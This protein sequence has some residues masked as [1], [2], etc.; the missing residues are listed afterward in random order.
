MKKLGIILLSA[1]LLVSSVSAEPA[2]GPEPLAI[3]W[4]AVA[5]AKVN[6]VVGTYTRNADFKTELLKGFKFGDTRAWVTVNWKDMLGF[7]LRVNFPDDLNS[8]GPINASLFNESYLWM[9]FKYFHTDIGLIENREASLLDDVIDKVKYGYFDPEKTLKTYDIGGMNTETDF[10][11][12]WILSAKIPVPA[13]PIRI[14]LSPLNGIADALLLN[15][16]RNRTSGNQW[17]DNSSMGVRVS[18]GMDKIFKANGTYQL[19]YSMKD[20]LKQ[21]DTVDPN[22]NFPPKNYTYTHK[23]GI[24]GE[25]LVLDDLKLVLGYSGS[26]KFNNRVNGYDKP[27]KIYSNIYDAIDLRVRYVGVP[28]FSFDTQHKFSFGRRIGDG[29]VDTDGMR[30]QELAQTSFMYWGA[31]GVAYYP[32][33]AWKIGLVGWYANLHFDNKAAKKDVHEMQFGLEPEVKFWLAKDVWIRGQ[34]SFVVTASDKA[35]KAGASMWDEL[36]M[37][38]QLPIS[39]NIGISR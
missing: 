12:S 5:F 15:V 34:V 37:K 14:D 17:S 30:Q 1:A 18:A 28:K 11:N 33:D 10:F 27:S 22:S 25:L 26:L 6:G 2:E 8:Q 38:L 7:R 20:E 4:G 35:A 23:Y 31:L 13:C 36:D 21:G 9:D 3:N 24:Y 19:A 29:Y 32:T 39:V 16:D